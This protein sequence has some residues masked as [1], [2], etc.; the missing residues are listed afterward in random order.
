MTVNQHISE[1][2]SELVNVQ[3]KNT[4]SLTSSQE[5]LQALHNFFSE[6]KIPYFAIFGTLL[7]CVRNH[8]LFSYDNDIDVA[9]HRSDLD[10]LYENLDKCLE[11]G[12]YVCETGWSVIKLRSIPTN[13]HIDIWVIE[14]CKAPGIRQL[15][16]RW[17]VDH[18]YFYQD[19]FHSRSICTASCDGIDV[20]VP[21]NATSLL[22]EWY[23]DWQ[24]PKY[25]AFAEYRPVLSRIISWPFIK[26]VVPF[27]F[28]NNP[29]SCYYRPWVSWLVTRFFQNT[30]LFSLFKH[31][32]N[33]DSYLVYK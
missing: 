8:A 9:I 13:L 30:A 29:K 22:T 19:Y 4:S 27:R 2:F 5:C 25:D 33:L 3:P 10:L 28:S 26:S 11:K 20:C 17:I 23:G 15:F 16:G 31:P 24:T 12:F 21:H 7:A 32:N 1:L 14:P 18:G 6:V